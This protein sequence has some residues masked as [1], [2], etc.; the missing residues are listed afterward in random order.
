MGTNKVDAY[1]EIQ[2][3]RTLML[4]GVGLENTSLIAC[5]IKSSGSINDA[6]YTSYADTEYEYFDGKQRHLLW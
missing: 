6:Q 2:G 4:D 5:R 3:G 1:G